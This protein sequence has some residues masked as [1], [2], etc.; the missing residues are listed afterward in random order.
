MMSDTP[1]LGADGPAALCRITQDAILP[2]T[3][4]ATARTVAAEPLDA[5]AAQGVLDRDAYDAGKRLRALLAASWPAQQCTARGRYV[6]AAS[7]MDDED[8]RQTDEEEWA[9]RKSAFYAVQQATQD[10]GPRDW[11]TVRAVCEG[12]W[13][14]RPGDVRMLR[15]GLGVLAA[16][17]RVQ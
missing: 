14:A 3:R 7:E 9:A 12:Y 13:I 8:E 2:G 10:V 4:R 15:R 5:Y 17:W 6:S 16:V 11:P 1:D